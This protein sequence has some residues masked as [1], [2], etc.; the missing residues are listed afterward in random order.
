MMNENEH[1]DDDDKCRLLSYNR[2]T[3]VVSPAPPL[4]DQG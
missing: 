1:D 3:S 4:S 2:G